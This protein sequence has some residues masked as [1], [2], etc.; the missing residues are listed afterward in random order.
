VGWNVSPV[1]RGCSTSGFRGGFVMPLAIHGPSLCDVFDTY[2]SRL[3][4]HAQRDVGEVAPHPQP[5]PLG[6][7]AADRLRVRGGAMAEPRGARQ[8]PRT[9]PTKGGCKPPVGVSRFDTS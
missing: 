4:F 9:P 3:Q 5:K 8:P 6:T 2:Q 1:R 7:V